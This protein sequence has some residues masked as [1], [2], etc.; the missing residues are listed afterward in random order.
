MSHFIEALSVDSSA[1]PTV[2][3]SVGAAAY[4]EDWSLNAAGRARAV[5]LSS[6]DAIAL[7]AAA[8]R[9]GAAQSNEVEASLDSSVR[10]VRVK[11]P[12]KA[13]PVTEDIDIVVQCARDR[14]S[15][16]VGKFVIEV[17]V[18]RGGDGSIPLDL[19]LH[20]GD[21]PDAL[22]P[23]RVV[24]GAGSDLYT[25]QRLATVPAILTC[26]EELAM[27][28]QLSQIAVYSAKGLNRRSVPNL[29]LRQLSLD[30]TPIPL[31]A[32]LA[33]RTAI[34]RDRVFRIGGTEVVDLALLSETSSG[35]MAEAS[36]G[37]RVP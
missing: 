2:L 3:R 23:G 19:Q 31:V 37:F 33:S 24:S 26:V 9:V 35:A 13:I 20:D 16:R 1:A 21:K 28:G 34:T 4:P 15:A 22:G 6:F 10:R 12:T 30:H 8:L 25:L 32:D 29:W 17:I 7:T 5:H 11:A 14:I 18:Q 36:F 27:F